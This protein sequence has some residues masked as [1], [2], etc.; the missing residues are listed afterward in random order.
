MSAAARTLPRSRPA[1]TAAAPARDGGLLWPAN[2]ALGSATLLVAAA[3]GPSGTGPTALAGVAALVL[4]LVPGN[5]RPLGRLGRS[6][7]VR[8][9][10]RRRRALGISA[11]VWWLAHAAAGLGEHFGVDGLARLAHPAPVLG[12]LALAILV[13]LLATSTT[14]AQ[15]R[16]GRRWKPLQRLVWF[17]VPLGLAHGV[18][19]SL[20]AGD[21]VL[22]PATVGLAGLVLFAA[23]ELWLRRRRGLGVP[24]H[25]RLVAAGVLTAL[26]LALA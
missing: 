6:R 2:A 23:A 17:A 9:L 4:C 8:Q 11:G 25:A 10:A 3:G 24:A 16:L 14:G 22:T 19:A 18:L 21:H 26:V 12:A 5:L 1:R 15:R 20:R 7:P 13:A